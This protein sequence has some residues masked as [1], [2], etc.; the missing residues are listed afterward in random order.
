MTL[1]EQSSPKKGSGRLE[2]VPRENVPSAFLSSALFSS[3]RNHNGSPLPIAR[4][5]M[6][7]QR[8]DCSLILG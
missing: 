1:E 4:D 3:Q 8:I 5:R 7:T 2:N 6:V